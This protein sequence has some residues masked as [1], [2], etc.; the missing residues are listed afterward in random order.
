MKKS[1]AINW[2]VFTF[3]VRNNTNHCNEFSTNLTKD[4]AGLFG[5]IPL[6]GV[7]SQ[8]TKPGRLFTPKSC[9]Q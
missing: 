7:V 1:F 6:H 2:N 8:L 5:F 3:T 9:E 4:K